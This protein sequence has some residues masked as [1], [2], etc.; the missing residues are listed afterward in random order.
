M[1]L[2][3][4]HTKKVTLQIKAESLPLVLLLDAQAILLN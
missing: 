3:K 4:L 1:A 2:D